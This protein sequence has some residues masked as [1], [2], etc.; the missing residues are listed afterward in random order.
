MP[1]SEPGSL[2]DSLSAA[3]RLSGRRLWGVDSSVSLEDLVQGSSLGDR[4]EEL[5]G[6]SILVATG[7]QLSAA[8]ALMELDGVARR[9]V[10]CPPDLSREYLPFVISTAAV[11]AVVSD[12]TADE[13]GAPGI[14]PFVACSVSITP[15]RTERARRYPTEWI[16]MTSGTTGPPKMVVHTLS[17]LAGAIKVSKSP[18]DP[19]TW[20]TFYDIRRYGGLQILLRALLG[21]GSLVLSSAQEPAGDFLIRAGARG[22]THILGTPTHWRT[23]LMSP[24]ARGLALKY[25]R[26]SGEIADQTILDH[27]R[28]FYPGAAIVHAYAS[29]EAGVGFEV[30]DGLAGFPARLIGQP[31]GDVEMK[32]EDGVLRIRSKRAATRYLANPDAAVAAADGFVDTGDMVELRGDRYYFAGRKGGIINVGGLKVHPEEVEA[33]I[34]SHPQVRMSLVRAKKS[35][36]T[37]ALVVAEVVLDTDTGAVNGKGQDIEQEILRHCRASLPRH[38]VP[39]AITF[40]RSLALASTGKIARRDA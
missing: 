31:G 1:Q 6:C 27:L 18:A 23:A 34:N 3:G 26:L 2:W 13:T 37:G 28:A 32:V 8:L 5:R 15:A 7:D 33:V 22:V 17:S 10:L 4:L 36:L 29:T 11:N 16:L 25:V 9:L 14:E 21:G 24:S 40:V 19:V 38:K 20:S 12:R 35:S 30:N 39:V